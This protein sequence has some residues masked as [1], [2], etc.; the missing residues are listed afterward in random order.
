MNNNKKS[1][2]NID[3]ELEVARMI[4]EGGANCQDYI[5]STNN[6]S[7]RVEE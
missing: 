1:Q 3:Y 7:N 2:E 6:E 5:I 4:Y